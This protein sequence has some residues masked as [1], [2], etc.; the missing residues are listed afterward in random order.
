MIR[1]VVGISMQPVL[2]PGKLVIGSKR[3]QPIIGNLVIVS[4]G[5]D[6]IIKRL[7]KVQGDKVYIIGDN[8][9]H[10]IDSRSYGWLSKDS[11]VATVIWPRVK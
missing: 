7:A 1:R 6:Q 2:S 10:S 9:D 11:I 4:Y 3:R 8:E 5:N